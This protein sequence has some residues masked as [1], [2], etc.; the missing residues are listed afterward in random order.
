VRLRPVALVVVLVL[1]LTAGSAALA[2]T[3]AA[4]PTVTHG[5]TERPDAGVEENDPAPA[6]TIAASA[7]PRVALTTTPMIVGRGEFDPPPGD[8][9]ENPG[10]L[11]LIDDGDQKTYW[12]TLC[13]DEPTMGSK[14]GV[15]LVL[16]LSTAA[17][18]VDM[19]ITSPTSGWSASVY[20]SEARRDKLTQ[21]GPPVAAVREARAGTTRIALGNVPGNYVL[22]EFT[23]LGSTDT[24]KLPYEMKVSEIS[25]CAAA[26]CPPAPPR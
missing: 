26:S 7:V 19:D 5:V 16:Q 2:Q 23:R 21:W 11:G 18:G 20:V 12:N 24:C 3:R 13:Y 14:H 8:G 9:R 25:V 15:G 1:V 10:R 17:A 4:R 22:L 6:S